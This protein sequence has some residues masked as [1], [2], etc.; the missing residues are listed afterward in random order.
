M[1]TV[2]R[3]TVT[4]PLPADAELFEQAGETLA[5][6]TVRGK[7]RTAATTTGTDG[8]RRLVVKSPY[9][10][11]KYR[12]GAGIVRTVPTKARTEGGARS[13]LADLERQAEKVRCG[14]LTPAESHVADAQHQPLPEH[15]AAFI[16]HKTARGLNAEVIRNTER[17][18]ARI[19]QEC[20]FGRLTDLNSD[21]FERWLGLQ[22]AA[23]M[24]PGNRNE[25]RKEVVGF[26]N[27]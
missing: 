14:I 9:F 25:Y 17:R 23:G 12:D 3:K 26:G 18:L 20:N 2:F 24:S 5:R 16:T 8:S 15:V 22:T 19:A 10:H 4:R 1:G 21:A 7:T 6:W 11:A 27:W 13:V